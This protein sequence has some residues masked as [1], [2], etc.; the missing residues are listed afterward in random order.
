MGRPSRYQAD[1]LVIIGQL[2]KAQGLRGELRCR[3]ETDF[4]ERFLSTQ[5]VELFRDPGSSARRVRLESARFQGN[6]L[7]V[8]LDGVNSPEQ[9]S[10]LT[11]S[12]VAVGSDEVVPMEDGFWHYE[13]EG[14]SVFDP[15]GQP[16]GKVLEVLSNPAHEIYR[17][18]SAQGTEMLVPAVPRYV[19]SIDLD[20]SRMVI[21]PPVYDED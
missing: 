20:Q 19:L 9:A 13:L 17:I 15:H 21:Q 16:L 18:G 3:P 7:L 8:K 4:P 5:E 6:L 10:A 14:L 1:Q 12:W 2:G 11:H